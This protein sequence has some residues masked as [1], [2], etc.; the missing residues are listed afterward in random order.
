MTYPGEEL[1]VSEQRRSMDERNSP[2][3]PSSLYRPSIRI[4]CQ[5]EERHFTDSSPFQINTSIKP[6]RLSNL[7]S[8][9]S[10]RFRSEIVIHSNPKMNFYIKRLRVGFH[11]NLDSATHPPKPPR[12]VSSPRNHS[13]AHSMGKEKDTKRKF[14]S[15]S[16][17]RSNSQVILHQWIDDLCAHERLML[18]EDIV[19]FLKNGEFLARI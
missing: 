11:D 2:S 4:Q 5:A 1:L 14:R 16:L 15:V 3:H 7:D 10:D 12:S 18:D 6:V 13:S 8:I 19:F 9:G 17:P